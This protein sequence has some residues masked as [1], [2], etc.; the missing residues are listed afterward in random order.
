[1]KVGLNATCL[2]ERP[3]GAKQ[4]FIGIYA[5]LFKRMPD[6]RFSVYQARNCDLNRCFAASSNVEFIDTPIPVDGRLQKFIASQLFWPENLKSRHFDIFEGYHLPFTAAPGA[7]NILTM[8]DIRGVSHYAGPAERFKFGSVLSVAFRA[9]DHVI[10]VSESMRREIHKFSA[11]VDSSV[12]YNGIDPDGYA[13]IGFQRLAEVKEKF[14]LPNGFLLSIGHFEKRK[15]YSRLID[16][17]ALLN[18][19]G[20]NLHLV[21]VGNESG[22]SQVIKKKIAR[23][24]LSGHVT[25]LHGISDSEVQCLYRLAGLFV[26]PSY[27]EGFGIPVLEAMASACPM[28][29]SDIPVFREITGNQGAFFPFDDVPAMAKAIAAV[30]DSA[31]E[32]RRLIALGH[33]RVKDFHFSAI[34]EKLQALYR[35]LLDRQRGI[36]P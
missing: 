32:R 20:R 12:I 36:R 29:L 3:S 10:T 23:S 9:A 5:E 27:Y 15:N 7:I 6:A 19:Q 4:R 31:D 34:A 11:G 26:F 14:D 35:T 28:V 24:G 8:H 18:R 22:E 1:M 2:G 30:L 25:V 33:Q 13:A 16:A 21:I 17:L